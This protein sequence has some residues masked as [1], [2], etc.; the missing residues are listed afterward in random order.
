LSTLRF[1]DAEIRLTEA[2]TGQLARALRSFHAGTPRPLAHLQTALDQAAAGVRLDRFEQRELYEALYAVTAAGQELPEPLAL[3][4]SRLFALLAAEQP[5]AVVDVTGTTF[6]RDV[7]ELSQR[8]PV[9][10]YFWAP[11]CGLSCR[12]L[13][14]VLERE[15]SAREGRVALAKVDVDDAPELAERLGIHTIPAIRGLRNG[16]IVGELDGPQPPKTVSGFVD[17]LTAATA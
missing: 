7:I 2:E 3:L 14:P 9:A 8:L 16:S 15:I 13:G 12:V 11:W 4:R 5:A 1:D 6:E 10:V 17:A